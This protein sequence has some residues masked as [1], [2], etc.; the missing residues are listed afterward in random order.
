M[1]ARQHAAEFSALAQALGGWMG[2]PR[3]SN[4]AASAKIA[5]PSAKVMTWTRPT[6]IPISPAAWAF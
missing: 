3:N 2:V 4:A 5:M 1:K 6:S